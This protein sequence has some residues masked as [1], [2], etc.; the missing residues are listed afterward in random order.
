M[1]CRGIEAAVLPV[2]QRYGLGVLVWSPLASGFLSGRVRRGQPVEQAMR[3]PRVQPGRFD[4]SRPENLAKLDATERLAEVAAGTGCSLPQMAVAFTLAH[5][6]VTSAI[7]GPR[8]LDQLQASL[9]GS[10]VILTDD[11]LDQ[12]D[13][14]V[15]PGTDLTR[16]GQWQPPALTDPLLRRR[17]PTDRAAA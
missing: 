16:D 10:T 14:V 9:A 15:P 3:R 11:Q 1:L 13:Q 8:T 2:C 4:L 12:I 7:L 6:A 5:P 17:P